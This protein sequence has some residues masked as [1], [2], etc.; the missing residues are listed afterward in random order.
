MRED[1]ND[2]DNSEERLILL[3]FNVRIKCFKKFLNLLFDQP[4]TDPDIP[5]FFRPGDNDVL[6]FEERF[7][8]SLLADLMDICIEGVLLGLMTEVKD[9]H[10]CL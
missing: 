4:I 7:S 1:D 8:C 9:R 10:K 5:D 3:K 2:D 6:S